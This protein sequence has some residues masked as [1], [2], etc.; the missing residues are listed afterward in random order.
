LHQRY[1]KKGIYLNNSITSSSKIKIWWWQD[2]TF[3]RG[4]GFEI[5]GQKEEGKEVE[6]KQMTLL[7]ING[8]GLC[9]KNGLQYPFCATE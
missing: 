7:D 8:N 1:I 2:K 6:L 3:I 9:G 4:T 5:G